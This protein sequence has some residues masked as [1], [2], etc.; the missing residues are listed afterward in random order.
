MAVKKKYPALGR[1]LSALID[2]E[3]EII[4]AGSSSI[5]EVAIEKIKAN[6]NQ[7]RHEFDKTA[8]FEL[9]K[10]IQEFGIIQPITLRQMEDGYYQII[11]GERRWRASQQVG[12]TKIP[13]YIRTADDEN[14]M[15]MA[16]VENIQRQDL[17]PIEIALAYQ[18]LIDQYN[19]TQDQLSDKVGK[20]RTAIANFIRLLKLPAPVQLALQDHSIDQGHARALLALKDPTLQNELLKEIKKQGYS[21]RQVEEM[22]KLLNAG[23][24]VKSGKTRLKKPSASLPDEYNALKMRL[25]Q[26]FKTKVQ[27][28]CSTAGRGRITIPFNSEEELVSIIGLFDKMKE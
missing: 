20:S 1:G 17:N 13:A 22:V 2:T 8:L 10:S 18:K 27:M 15:E 11:S 14:M 24:V 28:T 5:H 7:P 9:G 21:V 12:L 4:T 6:P 16:L 19:L 3:D 26:F 23:E 25:S